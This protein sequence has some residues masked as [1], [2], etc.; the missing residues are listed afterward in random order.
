M[1]TGIH[2]E[3]ARIGGTLV[4]YWHICKRQVW[5]M[6]H[7]IEPNPQDEYLALGRLIDQN[8]YSRERHQLTFG[9]DKFDFMQSNDEGV[10]I[11]E[12]KK[13]SRAEASA[14]MQ[15]AHYLYD[16]HKEGIE[17][18]GL[19][20]FPTERKRVEV[21]LTDELKAE[22]DSIYAGIHALTERATPPRAEM[23]K[24][25]GKCAYADYCWS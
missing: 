23:G 8:S 11:C 14:R 2:S 20:M 19:L 5:L 22:L 24:Y 16:L 3:N 15:L 10:V 17:A 21:E 6:S 7:G 25:C 12:V 9:D 13:S 18:R 1:E 4:W